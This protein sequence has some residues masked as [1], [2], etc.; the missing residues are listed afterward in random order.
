M[1]KATGPAV[2][3]GRT[4]TLTLPYPDPPLL[5][6][7]SNRGITWGARMGHARVVARIRGDVHILARAARI[8]ALTGIHVRLHYRPKDRRRRDPD[9]LMPTFKPCL[10]AL[11]AAG[12]VADD[13]QAY[14]DWSRPLIHEP[15]ADRT[16]AVWLVIEETL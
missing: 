1:P 6:N 9:G 12:I 14:V 5:A 8:P 15:T 2:T 3:K 11:V 7:R 4:W 10:D 13:T 16:P